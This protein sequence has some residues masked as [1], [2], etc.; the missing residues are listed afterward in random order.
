MERSGCST[1]NQYVERFLSLTVEIEQRLHAPALGAGMEHRAR[2]DLALAIE[3]EYKP[4]WTDAAV[5]LRSRR[6]FRRETRP[7]VDALTR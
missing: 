7:L 4:S 3:P 2:R 5:L 1:A 6:T